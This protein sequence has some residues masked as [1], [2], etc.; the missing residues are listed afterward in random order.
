LTGANNRIFTTERAREFAPAAGMSDAYLLQALHH[1][2]RSGWLIP[3]R[4]GL[5]AVS[6]AAPGVSPVHEFEIAMAL[7][8]PSAISH[9]SAMHYHGLTEQIPRRVFVLTPAG[10]SIPRLRGRLDAD[11]RDGFRVAGIVYQFVQTKP[12]WFFGAERVWIGEA[13]VAVTDP[14]RTLLDGLSKPQYCGDFAQSVHAFEMRGDRLNLSRIIDY[15][16]RLDVTTAKRLGWVLESLRVPSSELTAL[17]ELPA[18]G[19]GNLDRSGPRS[20]PHNR[21]WMLRVNLPG[22]ARQ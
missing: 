22:I 18:A 8:R 19:Y 4:K 1:L 15:A 2:T 11:N 21:R 3:L 9:W 12:E 17:A 13:Q 10:V 7:A 6:S 5:Y 14:E 16:L 20:G